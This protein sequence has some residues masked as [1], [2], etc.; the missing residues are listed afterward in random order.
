MQRFISVL[1][2][3][4]IPNGHRQPIIVLFEHKSVGVPGNP[5]QQRHEGFALVIGRIL[6]AHE[7][8]DHQPVFDLHALHAQA[9]GLPAEPHDVQQLLRGARQGSETVRQTAFESLQSLLVLR[10]V[11]FAVEFQTLGLLGDVVVRQRRFDLDVDVR[12]VDEAHLFDHPCSPS[13]RPGTFSPSA[14]SSATA[15]F[16]IFW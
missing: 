7:M 9:D 3:F 13:L 16:M 11:E 5:L 4:D 12:V 2:V 8:H 1:N 10:R 15:S 14:R 6:L